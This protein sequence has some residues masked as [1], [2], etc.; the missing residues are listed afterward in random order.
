VKGEEVIDAQFIDARPATQ[1][2]G[3]KCGCSAC[4]TQLA[5]VGYCGE[6]LATCVPTAQRLHELRRLAQ[7]NPAARAALDVDQLRHGARVAGRLVRDVAK[8][9]DTL[10]GGGRR[11]KR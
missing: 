5:T 2:P 1:R 11:L 8:I 3:F 10:A 4:H 7:T 6:C 9:V